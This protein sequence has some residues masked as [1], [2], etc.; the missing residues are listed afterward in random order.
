MVIRKQALFGLSDTDDKNFMSLMCDKVDRAEK[1]KSAVYTKFVAPREYNMISERLSLFSSI[2]SYGGYDGAER[3]IVCFEDKDYV[4]GEKEFPIDIL[5]IVAT[6]KKVYSHRDYLGS[7]LALG[8]KRELIG[9][10][11]ITDNEAL[12]FAMRKYQTT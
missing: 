4:F 8:I 11:I 10:I 1:I 12:Y 3:T 6:N 5:K 2:V 7:I 9:D